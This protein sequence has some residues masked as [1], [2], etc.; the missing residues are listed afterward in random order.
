MN[1]EMRKALISYAPE[2]EWYLLPGDAILN[3]DEAITLA[4]HSIFKAMVEQGEWGNVY[5]FARQK[6]SDTDDPISYPTDDESDKDY[7]D[8]LIRWLFLDPA[9]FCTLAGEWLMKEGK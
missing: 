6:W 1:D 5:I 9:R 7:D 3:A 8:T 4:A 2:S